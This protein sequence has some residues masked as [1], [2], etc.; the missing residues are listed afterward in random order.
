[1]HKGSQKDKFLSIYEF[2]TVH[3]ISEIEDYT[4]ERMDNMAYSNTLRNRFRRRMG[5]IGR[6][7]RTIWMTVAYAKQ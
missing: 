7:K 1:M 2:S 5:F 4:N 3:L 6:A